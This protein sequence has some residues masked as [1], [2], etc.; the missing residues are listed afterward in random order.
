MKNV[1]IS[2]ANQG[3]GYYMVEQLLS[4]GC[5]V[6]VLD[7]EIDNL[8][9]LSG[10]ILPLICDISDADAVKSCV[11]E[12]V[13]RFSSVDCAIHNACICTFDSLEQ[14][15]EE[16]YHRVFEVNYFGALNLTKAVLPN[17]KMQKNGKVIYTSSGVGVMG[18]VN[19]SPYASTK[20]ALESLT[21]C[22]NIEYCDYGIKFHIF[23]P[24]LTNTK[25]ASPLPVPKEF[26]ADP[27]K[28]GMGLAKNIKKKSY[29]ICHSFGQ[30][31]QTHLCY[32]FPI[33][34]GKLLSKMTKG[35]A[36]QQRTKEA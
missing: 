25:S 12:S 9:K 32:L 8:K 13:K 7:L 19:I 36:E 28:V 14:T 26:M 6:T 4:D 5:N 11:E 17:M 35:Y 29:I 21:K 1:I 20:G 18:F 16:T 30:K 22:L 3:I 10:N 33:K 2:G 24:P 31:V 15:S 34:M 23:H 27:K